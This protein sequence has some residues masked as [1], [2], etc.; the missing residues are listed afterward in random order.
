M[1]FLLVRPFYKKKLALVLKGGGADI[2]VAN[3][4]NGSHGASEF[5]WI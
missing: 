2:S 1:Y 5:R 4:T 3:G